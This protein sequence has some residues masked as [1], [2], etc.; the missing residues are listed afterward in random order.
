MAFLREQPAAIWN[1]ACGFLEAATVG[2]E[3]SE[4][5]LQMCYYLTAGFQLR[6]AEPFFADS[7]QWQQV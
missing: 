2:K 7:Y 1:P 6:P 5:G 3:V 4:C